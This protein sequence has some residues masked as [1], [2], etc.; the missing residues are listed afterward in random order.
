[1]RIFRLVPLATAVA[2]AVYS[3]Y[4]ADPFPTPIPRAEDAILVKFVDFA[5]I[6]FTGERAPRMMLLLDEPGTHR[7]F[8]HLMSGPIYAVSYDGKTVGEYLDMNAARAGVNVRFAS[9]D[10]G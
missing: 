4:T 8:V 3:Q 7:L 2:S 6:P 5:A 1:M 9:H 10:S